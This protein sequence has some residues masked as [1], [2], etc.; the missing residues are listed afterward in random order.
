MGQ[1]NKITTVI[2]TNGSTGDNTSGKYTMWKYQ[3]N[4]TEKEKNPE[5]KKLDTPKERYRNDLEEKIEQLHNNK[6]IVPQ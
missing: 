2:G 1:N 3:Q 4:E 6:I 5:G